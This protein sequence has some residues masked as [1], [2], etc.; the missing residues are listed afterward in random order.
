MVDAIHEVK[1]I[2]KEN[3]K[4]YDPVISNKQYIKGAIKLE[5]GMVLINDVNQFLDANEMKELEA[6]LDQLNIQE[7]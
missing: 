3:I 4:H 1:E 7:A 5:D 6:A 2:P